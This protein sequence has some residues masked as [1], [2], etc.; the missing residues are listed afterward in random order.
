[1]LNTKY[2]L[3]LN[4][5]LLFYY[6]SLVFPSSKGVKFLKKKMQLIIQYLGFK[7]SYMFFSK[8]NR[9]HQTLK[10]I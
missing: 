4:M 9:K 5:P 7:L 8:F 3:K 6:V 10:F 1:M 2:K